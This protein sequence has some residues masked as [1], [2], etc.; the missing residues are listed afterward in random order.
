MF[1]G[2]FWIH[3][4]SASFVGLGMILWFGIFRKERTSYNLAALLG[5]IVLFVLIIISYFYND[6][7]F[8]LLRP[9]GLG[10]RILTSVLL[11]ILLYAFFILPNTRRVRNNK[12]RT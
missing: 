1:N 6:Y 4:F 9:L 12:N 2:N 3:L 11:V 10:V 7:I 5:S 8:D